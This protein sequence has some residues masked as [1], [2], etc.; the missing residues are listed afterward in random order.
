MTRTRRI[1]AGGVVAADDFA[2]A[3]AADAFVRLAAGC[4]D[5]GEVHALA[6]GLG[7]AGF[8]RNLRG[9]GGAACH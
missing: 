1:I 7:D 3:A 5:L 8:G 2:G 4:L 9:S 6:L